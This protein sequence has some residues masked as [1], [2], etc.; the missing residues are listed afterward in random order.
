MNNPIAVPAMKAVALEK[1]LVR[2]VEIPARPPVTTPSAPVASSSA[3]LRSKPAVASQPRTESSPAVSSA[4]IWGP[5]STTPA[6]AM[7]TE[8]MPMTSSPSRTSA[9]AALRGRCTASQ[10]TRGTTRAPTTR[11]TTS[12]TTSPDSPAR[13]TYTPTPAIAMPTV[14]HARRPRSSNEP[15]PTW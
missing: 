3:V 8:P 4:R 15:R 7:A 14:A 9:D 1:A 11:A 6:I 5:W 13:T 12:G 10:S 2:N